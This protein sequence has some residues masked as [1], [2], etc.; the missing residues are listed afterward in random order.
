MDFIEIGY[1]HGSKPQLRKT[2]RQLPIEQKIR[3]LVALQRVA[4]PILRMRGIQVRAWPLPD[5]QAHKILTPH[6]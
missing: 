2:L 4:I 3:K 5:D 6:L 1:A